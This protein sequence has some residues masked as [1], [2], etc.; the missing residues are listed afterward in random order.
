L[1]FTFFRFATKELPLTQPQ[2]GLQLCKFFFQYGF[3]RNGLLMDCMPITLL[4]SQFGK[5]NMKGARGAR[6]GKRTKAER[7]DRSIGNEGLQRKNF[8]RDGGGVFLIGTNIGKY[9]SIYL[10]FW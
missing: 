6:K 8:Y 9:S 4:G 2:L 7:W 5:L 1:V 3:S 10:F